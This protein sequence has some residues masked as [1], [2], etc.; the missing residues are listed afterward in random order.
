MGKGGFS[1][2]LQFTQVRKKI[3]KQQVARAVWAQGYYLGQDKEMAR[4]HANNVAG[5][6]YSVGNRTIPKLEAVS[7]HHG[8]SIHATR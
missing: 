8:Y 2:E 3:L 7:A 1:K 4:K 5:E 6:G